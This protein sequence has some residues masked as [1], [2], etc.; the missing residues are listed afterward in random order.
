VS[1]GPGPDRPLARADWRQM[2]VIGLI[3]SAVGIALGLW[4]N[5]F[6]VGASKQA[7]AIDTL[8]DVLIIASVPVFVLV[9][10]VVLFS[11]W[12]FRMR[13]GEELLDGPPIH[14]NTRLEIIWTTIPAILLVCL[15]SYAYLVLRDVERADA[16]PLRVRVVGQQFA[17]TFYYQAGPGREVE[18]PELYLP[19]N[20]QVQFTLQSRDVIHDFWVPAFRIKKDAVPGIDVKYVVK[21]IKTGTYAIVCAELCGLGH[22]TM[23]GNAHVLAPAA[24][25]AWLAKLKTGKKA[26]AG[27][28]T[29]APAPNAKALFTSEGC[30]ACHT[31]ADAGSTGTTGP[32]LNQFLKGKPPAFIKQSIVDPNAVI[33]PGYS[34]NIMPPDFAQKMTPAEI[35]AL[36]KYLSDVTKGG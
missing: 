33:A 19:V 9:T 25:N 15:C 26:P 20:R 3:A 16:N 31:L 21:P 17:W 18:S 11:V 6:P 10:T 28:G 23:R 4:I 14:G 24:Y 13:P 1:S 34:A 5:W 22:S 30:A 27:G 29:S 12:K 8:W 36:V 2:L 35:D 32:N 7:H